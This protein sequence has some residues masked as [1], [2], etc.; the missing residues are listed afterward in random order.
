MR[1]LF[2]AVRVSDL[3]ASIAFYQA[4]GMELAGRVDH[5]RSRMAMLALPRGDE[6]ILELVQRTTSTPLVADCSRPVWPP[7]RSRDQ[8]ALTARGR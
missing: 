6:V 2:P 5:D 4:I 1:I 3:V 7:V 8:V